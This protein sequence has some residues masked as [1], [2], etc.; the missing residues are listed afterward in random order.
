VRTASSEPP[1]QPHSLFES[2]RPPTVAERARGYAFPPTLAYGLWLL[3]T[4]LL[5]FLGRAPAWSFRVFGALLL[6]SGC[7]SLL[8]LLLLAV[9]ERR[10]LDWRGVMWLIIAVGIALIS[11]DTG[12]GLA[13]P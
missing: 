13:F 11:L 1:P 4:T 3:F 2:I 12:W 7:A 5:P 10:A 9:R 6:L 8:V